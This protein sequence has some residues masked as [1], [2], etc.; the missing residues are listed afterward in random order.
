LLEWVVSLVLTVI[1]VGF[2]DGLLA[3]C[4]FLILLAAVVPV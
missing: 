2:C 4:C 1:A 3:A